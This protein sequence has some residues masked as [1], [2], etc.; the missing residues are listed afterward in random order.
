MNESDVRRKIYRLLREL[1]YWPIT[2]TN[3]SICP[4]CKAQVKPTIGRPDILVLHPKTRP[5]V[6]E[7]KCLRQ[8]ETSF[9]FNRVTPEQHTWLNRWEEDGGLGYLALGV[10]RPHR[11]RVYLDHLWLVDWAYWK[12]IEGLVSPIQN[13]I[14]LTAGKGMRQELQAHQLDL[15]TLLRHCSLHDAATGQWQLPAGH[16]AWPEEAH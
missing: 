7:V 2:N 8:S 13:S 4:R 10:L 11:S 9:P 16:S 15:L 1:D 5:I 3:T 6:V 12:E 14:P